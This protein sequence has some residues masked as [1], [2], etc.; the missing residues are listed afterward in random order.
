MNLEIN[1]T[2]TLSKITITYVKMLI[3]PLRRS[4][5]FQI[6]GNY[7]DEKKKSFLRINFFF[8]IDQ[9]MI[10]CSRQA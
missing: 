10:N 1:L 7:F 3:L 4:G 6:N 5:Q 9:W 2:F 8:T